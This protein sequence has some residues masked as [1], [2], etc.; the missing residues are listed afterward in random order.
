MLLDDSKAS[1]QS[2][3]TSAT[4]R[5]DRDKARKIV[6]GV[7]NYLAK[8]D[9]EISVLQEQKSKKA[10]LKALGMKVKNFDFAYKGRDLDADTRQVD[11]EEQSFC[12]EALDVQMDL[13]QAD[14]EERTRH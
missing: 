12:C 11:D 1:E 8:K 10:E 3:E 7:S 13:F 2:A 5:T 9:K 4:W 6:R 14:G